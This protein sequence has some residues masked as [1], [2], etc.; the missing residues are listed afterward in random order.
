M[1]QLEN[2]AEQPEG[3]NGFL[4][5]YLVELGAAE[6]APLIQAAFGAGRAD[7]VI[8]GDW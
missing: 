5:D 6:A 1:R 2:W 3:L 4:I 7:T 8:R